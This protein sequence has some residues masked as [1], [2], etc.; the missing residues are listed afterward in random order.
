MAAKNPGDVARKWSRNLGGSMEAVKAGVNAVTVSPAEKALAQIDAYLQGVTR[1]VAD[2][3]VQ[4]GLRRVT[5]ED[6]KQ[7]ML[8]KGVTRIASGASAAIPKMERFLSEFLPHV[9][10]GQRKLEGMPRGDLAQNIQRA[11][12]MM[13]HNAQFRRSA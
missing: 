8:N 5:L 3:K 11:V 12:M 7:A 4:A 10:A 9:E 2:G 1:A 6:C 13:E